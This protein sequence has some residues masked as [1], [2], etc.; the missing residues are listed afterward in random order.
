MEL[1]LRALVDTSRAFDR[2]APTY[3]RDNS[4]NPIICAM[5]DRTLARVTAS[6]HPGSTLLDLGCGPGLDAVR[7]ARLGYLISAVDSS[8]GM[9]QH[10]RERIAR[11]GLTAR[12]QLRTLGIHQLEQL[13]DERFDGAFSNFGPLNCVPDLG[14]AALTLAS[15]LRPGGAFVA[16]VIGRVCPWEIARYAVTGDWRRIAMRFARDFV[17]VPLEGRTVWTRYY[18]PSEFIAVFRQAGFRLRSLEALG[19][20]MPPPYLQGVHH[21]HPGLMR[22][23]ERLERR[24]AG[25]PGLRHCGDHFLVSMVRE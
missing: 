3:G 19:L 13:E 7:L 22:G 1:T 12:V 9:V 4:T 17:P 6:V 10:A 18:L 11:E 5:R 16:S 14:A 20:C 23:L 25:W 21:R 15:R 8:R 24:V 2:V